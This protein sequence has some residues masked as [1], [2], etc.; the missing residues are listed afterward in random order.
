VHKDRI[1]GSRRKVDLVKD[2]L[3]RRLRWNSSI[4]NSDSLHLYVRS[5]AFRQGAQLLVVTPRFLG[6][7]QIDH[8]ADARI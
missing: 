1:A 6:F 5:P 2:A 8:C 7:G 4:N 3:E